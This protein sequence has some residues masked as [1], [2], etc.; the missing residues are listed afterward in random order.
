MLARRTASVIHRRT[1]GEVTGPTEDADQ[2]VARC[3]GLEERPVRSRACRRRG[4]RRCPMRWPGRT[5][6]EVTGPAE[7]ADQGVARCG[8][9]EERPVR[10]PGPQRTRTQRGPRFWTPGSRPGILNRKE[11]SPCVLAVPWLPASGVARS[12]CGPWCSFPLRSSCPSPRLSMAMTPPAPGALLPS[13]ARRCTRSCSRKLRAAPRTPPR[14]AR[15]SHD[16][17]PRRPDRPMRAPSRGW[18]PEA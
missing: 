9:L 14:P 2:G 4:P 3:G 17:A 18:H 12:F 8:G 1:P 7:D 11:A 6:G 10:S 15:H 13:R 16:P 5:P